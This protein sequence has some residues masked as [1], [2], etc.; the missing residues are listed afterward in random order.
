MLKN[1]ST[2]SDTGFTIITN[3]KIKCPA[4]KMIAVYDSHESPRDMRMFGLIVWPYTTYPPTTIDPNKTAKTGTQMV[5]LINQLY[6]FATHYYNNTYKWVCQTLLL[7]Q[8]QMIRAI[9]YRGIGN[10]KHDRF[11]IINIFAY[12]I[13]PMFIAIK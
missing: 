3:P 12:F 9:L 1:D 8:L 5:I 6:F 13:V 11:T 4:I 2:C 10:T 7:Q